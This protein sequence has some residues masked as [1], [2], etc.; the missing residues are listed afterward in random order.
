MEFIVKW[1]DRIWQYEALISWTEHFS[2]AIKKKM[3]Q[4]A[5]SDLKVFKDVKHAEMLSI[6]QGNPVMTLDWKARL[7][8][9]GHLTEAPLNRVY[10]SVVSL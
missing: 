5:V 9:D 4:N 6:V 1:F 3:L 7:V 2:R 8:A 10:S